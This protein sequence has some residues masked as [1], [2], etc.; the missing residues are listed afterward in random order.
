MDDISD[1]II[2]IIGLNQDSLHEFLKNK[3]LS[4]DPHDITHTVFFQKLYVILLNLPCYLEELNLKIRE[5][6]EHFIDF[7]SD[8]NDN[9]YFYDTRG[10]MRIKCV[11]LSN[12]GYLVSIP[13]KTGQTIRINIDINKKIIS[14]NE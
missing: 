13:V 5:S 2:Q 12:N 7:G 3:L 10:F 14:I 4:I 8:F 6:D 9:R 11:R 1:Y